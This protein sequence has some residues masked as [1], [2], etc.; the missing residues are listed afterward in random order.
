[1]LPLLIKNKIYKLFVINQYNNFTL[2]HTKLGPPQFNAVFG[3][4]LNAEGFA[5]L[6]IK[7]YILLTSRT[8]V[9]EINA[10]NLPSRI[11]QFGDSC[12]G[13]WFYNHNHPALANQKQN[14]NV[15][16]LHMTKSH[17]VLN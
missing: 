15:I 5:A 13:F 7:L 1:M 10:H 16:W 6:F 3:L 11:S 2:K 14:Q 17:C 12:P 9:R 8:P 4:V